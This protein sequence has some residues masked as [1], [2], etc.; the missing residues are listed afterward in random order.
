MDLNFTS[1]SY[2]RSPT[3]GQRGNLRLF[4]RETHIVNGFKIVQ[5]SYPLSNVG[6]GEDQKPS[7][8]PCAFCMLKSWLEFKSPPQLLVNVNIQVEQKR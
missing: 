1:M 6:D 4:T 7:R 3:S 5:S 2:V 8:E